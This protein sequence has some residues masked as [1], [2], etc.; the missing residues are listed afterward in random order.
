MATPATQRE[1]GFP[2]AR[3]S[4]PGLMLSLLGAR[5]A[6]AQAG[7]AEARA[8]ATEA[9]I[10]L[11][12]IVLMEVTRAQ[13]VNVERAGQ[14]PGRGP[15]N[16]IV[17]MREFPSAE[18]R[19]VVRPNFDTLYSPAWIDAAAEPLILSL[20]DTAGPGGRY[21]L[22]P[23]I[24][25]WTNVFAVPGSRTSGKEAA[26][27]ALLAPGW[28]GTLPEGIRPI[29]MPTPTAW[30][31]GRTQTNGAS[32]YANVHRQQDGYRLVPLSRRGQPQAEV[33]G[34]VD[35]SVD[36]RTPPMLTVERMPAMAF[37]TLGMRLLAQH[38]P[39]AYDWPILARM[40]RIGLVA[41]RPFDPAAAPAAARAA[42]EAAPAEAMQ[43]IQQA[44]PGI[45]QQR[46]RWQVITGMGVYGT[47][48]LARAYVALVG[49]GMNLSEDAIYPGTKVDSEGRRLTGEHRYT[50]RFARGQEPPTNAFWSL[51]MYDAQGFQVANPIHRFAIG[52]RDPLVRGAD[53]S[54]ELLIQ[55][56]DPGPARRANWLP[57][58]ARGPFEP[59]LRI[60]SPRP[61]VADG[62][63]VPP[64]FRRIG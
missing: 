43:R 4:L 11:Y 19:E 7:D 5:G 61:E 12:P 10:Y 33:T 49:L 24:D 54:I 64:M 27:F 29:R 62:R 17:H 48:Y 18:F 13:V 42:L 16:A 15:M 51:T 35:P 23:L 55:H 32:D 38:G 41:G 58:P 44:G 34:M 57:A 31:I 1:G 52:D 3:R 9:Y 39:G 47:N 60:Y 50:L 37:F 40:A 26:E 20:P 30:L 28:T 25:M 22:M 46:N 6:W 56:A 36:P 59:T 45:G 14:L 8:I 53:G 21:F 63:W 2:L